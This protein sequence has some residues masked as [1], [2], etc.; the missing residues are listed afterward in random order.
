MLWFNL[1]LASAASKAANQA[2]TK[3]L[4]RDFSVLQVAAYGQLAAGLLILPLFI[5]TERIDIPGEIA[6]HKAAAIT[7]GLNIIAI[8]LL[9]EAIRKSDLSYA[10]PLLGLTP[11]FSIFMGW[12]I[13]GEVIGPAGVLGILLVFAGA[14]AIDARSPGDWALLG[15]RRIFRDPGVL[16]VTVVACIYSISSVYDKTATLLS[17]PFTFVW[18]S[19]LVRAVALMLLLF[20]HGLANRSSP[21]IGRPAFSRLLLFALLG[22]TFLAEALSQMYALQTGLVAYVIAVKRLSILMT[23]LAGMILYGEAF[24]RA[25]LS[26]AALIVAGAGILYIS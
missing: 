9:I 17:D 19:A 4:T 14:L 20:G 26:G 16:L 15:G 11:V 3:A 1:S 10:L 21:P 7:I 22:V 24:S 6:F 25:R 23:S 13:R 12:I 8:I 18:Y 2:I 5:L